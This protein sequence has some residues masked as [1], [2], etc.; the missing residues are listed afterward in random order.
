MTN[1]RYEVIRAMPDRKRFFS[2]DLFPYSHTV[3]LLILRQMFRQKWK[4]KH[5]EHN[6][7]EK[8]YFIR[9]SR[10]YICPF[11]LFLVIVN[12]NQNTNYGQWHENVTQNFY[13]N[14]FNHFLFSVRT[15]PH[16]FGVSNPWC[17]FLF[18]LFVCVYSDIL[19]IQFHPPETLRSA[20]WICEDDSDHSRAPQQW[21]GSIIIVHQG[22]FFCLKKEV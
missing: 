9:P 17:L 14:I 4:K 21:G 15:F 10:A 19:L 8:Q 22:V 11:V 16:S 2:I 5:K 20:G 1:I 18:V 12:F 3:L 7:N 13:K 6:S